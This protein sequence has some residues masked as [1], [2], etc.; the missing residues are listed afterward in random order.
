MAVLINGGVFCDGLRKT[1]PVGLAIRF[2]FSAIFK[3]VPV[4][5]PIFWV[6]K[7]K[8]VLRDRGEDWAALDCPNRPGQAGESML[9]FDCVGAG[10]KN[11]DKKLKSFCFSSSSDMESIFTQNT[12]VC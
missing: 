7:L 1:E 9:G 6:F 8:L 10:S 5:K 4:S 11:S 2:D 3:I 12:G